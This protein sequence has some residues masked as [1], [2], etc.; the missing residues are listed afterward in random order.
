VAERVLLNLVDDSLASLHRKGNLRYVDELY[1]PLGYFNQVHHVSFWSEDS[2]IRFE[3]PT[4][5]LHVLRL[6]LRPRR[7][8]RVYPGLAAD[9]ARA[10]IQILKICR[11]YRVSVIRAR[12]AYSASAFGLLASRILRVPLVVSLGAETNRGA[13]MQLGA[14]PVL[15]SRWLSCR[16]EEMVLRGAHRVLV[17]NETV[18]EYAAR[19]GVGEEQL[20]IVQLRPRPEFFSQAH[21]DPGRLKRYGVDPST[22]LVLYVGRLDL[23][24]DVLSLV[25]AIPMVLQQ[26]PS[27]QFIFLGDGPKRGAVE[28]RLGLEPWHTRVFLLGFQPTHIVREFLALATVVWIPKAGFAL[29]EAAAAGTALVVYDVEWQREL[30]VNDQTGKLVPYL[31]A[32]RLAEAVCDLLGD[33]AKAVRLKGALRRKMTEQFHPTQLAAREVQVYEE[34]LGRR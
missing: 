2:G 10:L 6:T 14:W 33:P 9:V 4:I 24:K 25:D 17:P 13:Y 31:D 1:N 34:L 28:Q 18:R 19:L 32:S 26:Y 21:A 22:P 15:R 23:D 8:R 12:N 3:N 11:R 5:R 30:I 16:V 27:T 20:R 29:L 7:S